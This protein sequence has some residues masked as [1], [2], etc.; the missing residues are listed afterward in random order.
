MTQAS[1]EAARAVAAIAFLIC[2]DASEITGAHR[3]VDGGLLA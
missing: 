1:P 2:D 3:A